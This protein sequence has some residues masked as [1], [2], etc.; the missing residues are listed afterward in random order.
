M[1]T[2]FSILVKKLQNEC[3]HI[4]NKP[5]PFPKLIT[6]LCAPFLIH[7]FG[8]FPLIKVCLL[9]R[10]TTR[11]AELFGNTSQSLFLLHIF[12]LEQVLSNGEELWLS[13]RR[14]QVQFP[15]SLVKRIRL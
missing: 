6:S 9:T 14:S 3:T 4:K 5:P 1:F 15:V 7:S 13:G 2:T 11:V 10:E 12:N 8:H